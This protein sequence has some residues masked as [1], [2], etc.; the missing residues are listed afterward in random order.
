MGDMAE[1]EPGMVV[2]INTGTRECYCLVLIPGTPELGFTGH[3]LEFRDKSDFGACVTLEHTAR[4]EYSCI[5]EV[6]GN[7]YR[8]TYPTV[9][10]AQAI[11]RI[12]RGNT[13]YLLW[14]R[15]VVKEMTIDEISKKVGYPVKIV[16]NKED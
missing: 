10:S 4:Y 2:K 11:Q 7:P 6:F 8:A 13:E 16:G 12:F 15:Q 5:L 3:L 14:K 1:I 9:L